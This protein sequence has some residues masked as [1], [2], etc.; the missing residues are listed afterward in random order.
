MNDAQLQAA[1][2]LLKEGRARLIDRTLSEPPELIRDFFAYEDRP[3]IR[4]LVYSREVLE[5]WDQHWQLLAEM[6][7]NADG[8]GREGEDRSPARDAGKLLRRLLRELQEHPGT[9]KSLSPAS[10][11]ELT[12][13]K[14]RAL[15]R[16]QATGDEHQRAFVRLQAERA[17]DN[18][19]IRRKIENLK[20]NTEDNGT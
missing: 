14:H 13:R 12:R 15:K 19:I 2:D 3:A 6:N 20:D 18:R 5:W 11:R 17:R 1:L 7:Q 4:N 10:V 16:L 9:S 8:G